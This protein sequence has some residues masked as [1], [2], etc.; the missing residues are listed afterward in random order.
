MQPNRSLTDHTFPVGTPTFLMT[1]IEGSTRV[2][3]ASPKAAKVALQRHDD[4]LQRE[5]ERNEGRIVESGREG[6][7]VLAVFGQASDAIACA[8]D[9]QRELRRATWPEGI[10]M[11]VRIAIHTGEAE[12]YSGHYVGASLYRCARLMGTAHGGQI[13]VSGAT[14][15]IVA[16][17]LPDESSLRDLGEHHLPDLMRPE[18]VYQLMHPDV[19]ADFPPLKVSEPKR[20]N[21]VSQLTAFVGRDSE[22]NGLTKAVDQARLVT[23]L[24]PGGVGKTRLAMEFAA[25]S[26]ERWADGAW[27][28]DLAPLDDPGRLAEAVATSLHLRPAGDPRVQVESWL[29]DKH[30]L[31]LLD[32]CEHLIGPC[33]EFCSTTLERCPKVNIVATS[34][35]ALG[36]AGE[37]RMPIGPMS[38]SDALD[39][40]DQRARLIR[41]SFTLTKKNHDVVSHICRRLDHLPLALELVAA[42]LGM[43]TEPEILEQLDDRFTLLSSSRSS[44]RRHQTLEATIDWSYRLLT[45]SEAV[46]FRRL[47]V[48]RDGCTLESAQAICTD[49]LVPDAFKALVGLVDKSM[50][51]V[52]QVDDLDTRY[53]LLESQG[54]Y[55]EQ[56]LSESGELSVV[57]ERHH[58][59]FKSELISRS[60]ALVG[61]R[62]AQRW[63]SADARTNN[64][65]TAKDLQWKQG[66]VEN[67]WAALQWAR[68]NTDDLGLEMAYWV[69]EAYEGDSGRKRAWLTDLIENAPD[70]G[71]ITSWALGAAGDLAWRQNDAEGA[72][73]LGKR[74]YERVIKSGEVLQQI[75]TLTML[76]NAE[77]DLG[78][79]QAAEEA[80]TQ[81][82]HL[83]EGSDRVRQIALV[84]NNLGCLRLSQGRF[85]EAR[86][87]L[88]EAVV[89]IRST[90]D[91]GLASGIIESWAS[92][93]LAC[94]DNAAAELSWRKS[95]AISRGATDFDNVICCIGGLVASAASRGDYIRASQLAGAHARL[96][97]EYSYF[98]K[99]FWSDRRVAWEKV[100]AMKLGARYEQAWSHGRRFDLQGAIDFALDQQLLPAPF[101]GE[102]DPETAVDAGPLSRREREVAILV[103]AG[104]TNRE[105]AERL[106]IAERSA[107]GHVERIRNKLGVRSRTEVATWAVEHG[108]TTPPKKETGTQVGSLPTHR[109]QPS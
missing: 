40:F 48:F 64:V 76:G 43:F 66:E 67:F 88:E 71:S 84:K 15:E 100:C 102:G 101:T 2:W 9:M 77:Q 63:L 46:L 38:E 69:T 18:N 103:A 8:L 50:V 70:Q 93:Q 106:F 59:Y 94:G 79:L 19:A 36:I 12:L 54:A 52:E 6:D 57:C 95:I 21:L 31:L 41:P 65:V 60:Q 75:Q 33:A 10:E 99:E 51:S 53:R 108:L 82:I 85:T 35:E 30:L 45:E 92:A 22:L 86:S 98:E 61:P 62:P 72:V 25:K 44:D 32:N 42:R 105:I 104:L 80:H 23:L 96:A 109:G 97:N 74:R 55:A 83:L 24:G 90:S 14:R 73:R 1:D 4:I 49:D 27:L 87:I 3:D 20:S 91:I 34:R 11:K 28:I 16:D 56:R 26:P 78:H 81:A 5:I 47:S 29:R 89:L 17:T 13:L 107:E 7:S 37:A 39:L 58:Q 68:H